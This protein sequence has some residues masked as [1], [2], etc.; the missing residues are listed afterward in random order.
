[1]RDKNID[2]FLDVPVVKLKNMKIL[3]QTA[4]F[5]PNNG[6]VN[7]NGARNWNV[8]TRCVKPA[9]GSNKTETG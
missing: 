8:N 3:H 7:C 5:V 2:F 9:F 6:C 4:I 1:M